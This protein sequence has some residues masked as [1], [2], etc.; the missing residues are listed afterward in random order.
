MQILLS[1]HMDRFDMQ[2]L[3][4]R[5]LRFALGLKQVQILPICKS[6]KTEFTWTD[7]PTRVNLRIRKICIRELIWSCERG[8]KHEMS[9][10]NVMQRGACQC[11]CCIS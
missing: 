3:R 7:L 9:F 2:N 4:T 6:G 8:F 1:V 5:E 10:C 11:P